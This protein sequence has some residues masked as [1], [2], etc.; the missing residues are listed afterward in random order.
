MSKTDENTACA[1]S[2]VL[3]PITG[4]YFLLTDKRDKVR[5]HGAQSTVL[6]GG[7]FV[8]QVVLGATVIFAPLSLLLSVAGFVLWLVIIYKTWEGNPVVLPVVGDWARKM[9][10][11]NNQN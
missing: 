8:L 3:G 9:A 10:K 11:R 5:F 6:F 1:L 7:I 4:V 2:Y